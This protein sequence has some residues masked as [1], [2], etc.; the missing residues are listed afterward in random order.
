MLYTLGAVLSSAPVPLLAL[1][2]LVWCAMGAI[3][4]TDRSRLSARL[5][6]AARSG[7][8]GDLQIEYWDR[9]G[10]P[11]PG[12]ESDQLIL[13]VDRGRPV[14][15][16]TRARFDGAFDPPFRAEERIA[17]ADLAAARALCRSLAELDLLGTTFP[18]EKPIAVGGATKIT[19]TVREGK[20][21]IART[22]HDHLPARLAPLKALVQAH[23][24]AASQAVPR[25]L[26]RRR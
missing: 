19:V 21:E 11:G 2:P 4:D 15:L 9:G 5:A 7:D 23:I 3:F 18:E 10:P 20:S 24:D 8:L 17:P 14:V 25:E 13:K 16:H 6:E 26:N 12:Y 22:Y 1:G